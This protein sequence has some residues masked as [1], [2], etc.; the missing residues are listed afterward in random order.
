MAINEQLQDALNDQVTAEIEASMLYLQLSYVMDDM[1][2]LGMSEWMKK[3]HEEELE[4]AAKFSQHLLDREI[5]PQINNISAPIVKINSAVEAFEAALNHE[6]SVSAKIR[7]LAELQDE[8]KDWDS[9][10]LINE[11][12][13]EQI[14]E[15]ATVNDILDRLRI[16]GESGSGILRIDSEL[17]AR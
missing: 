8:H 7:R 11:F 4:H 3:Q 2:L 10:P 12:L 9:R 6:R 14:E 16:A 13:D 15:E 5:L 17:G 1:G